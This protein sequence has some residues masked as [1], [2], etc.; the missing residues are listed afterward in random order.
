MKK[1]I[2]DY[3]SPEE[4]RDIKAAREADAKYAKM[5]TG[6]VETHYSLYDKGSEVFY[7]K[8]LGNGKWQLH[9][10][11]GK[12]FRVHEIVPERMV[13]EVLS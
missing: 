8:D 5:Y 7:I 11:P 6:E 13:L 1:D 4:L 9:T 12:H 10:P 2:D 3:L